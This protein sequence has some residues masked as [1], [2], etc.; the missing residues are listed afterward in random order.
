MAEKF[1]PVW[2]KWIDDNEAKGRPAK[3]V[4]K[5]YVKIMK[6]MGRPVIMKLPGLYEN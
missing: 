5:A 4:Y 3:A 1:L 2:Q 6:E